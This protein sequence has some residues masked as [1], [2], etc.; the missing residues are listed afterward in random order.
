MTFSEAVSEA[1]EMGLMEKDIREDLSNR[2]TAR[3]LLILGI[4]LGLIGGGR[5]GGGGS[6]IER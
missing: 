5:G 4:E 2:Y 6:T 3:N 1:I